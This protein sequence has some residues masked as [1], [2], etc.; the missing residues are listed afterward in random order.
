MLGATAGGVWLIWL[1]SQKSEEERYET[2]KEEFANAQYQNAARSFQTLGDDFT[3]SPR[4]KEY[5][6]MAGLSRALQPAYELGDPKEALETLLHFVGEYEENPLLQQQKQAVHEG[7]AKVTADLAEAA[8][9]FLG[10]KLDLKQARQVLDDAKRAQGQIRLWGADDPT[11]EKVAAVEAA[12]G[13]AERRQTTLQELAAVPATAAGIRQAEQLLARNDLQTDTEAR[14]V[15]DQLKEKFLGTIHY[16]ESTENVL[17]ARAEGRDSHLILVAPV[18]EASIDADGVL[19]AM[20]RGILYALTEKTGKFLWATRVGPDISHL[21]I[22]LVDREEGMEIALVVTSEPTPALVARDVRSGQERWHYSL[23]APCLGRP[24][25]VGSHVFI[26]TLDGRIHEIEAL[27]GK[28]LGWYEVG[29]PFTVG[30]TREDGSDRVYFP[31]DSQYVYVFN[32]AARKCVGILETGHPSGSVRNEPIVVRSDR[33][34]PSAAGTAAANYLIL[35]QTEGLGSTRLRAFPLEVEKLVQGT[36]LEPEP[37]L[38]GWS[39]FAPACDGEKIALTTDAGIFALFG[40]NQARNQDTPLFRLWPEEATAP[41]RQEASPPQRAQVVHA[42]ENDFWVLLGGKL[43]QWRLGIDREKG[44]Q[45]TKQWELAQPLGSPV[46][47]SQVDQRRATLFVVSQPPSEPDYLVTAVATASGRVQWQQRL[48]IVLRGDAV[49]VDGKLLAMNQTSSLMR[50]DP[51]RDGTARREWQLGGQR[52]SSPLG[53][54]VQRAPAFLL[55]APDGRTVYSLNVPTKGTAV[56][57]RRVA[58]GRE[59]ERKT[60]PLSAP[61]AGTPA[62]GEDY[63]LLPL[64]DGTLVWQPWEGRVRY[65]TWRTLQ[66]DRNARGHVVHLGPGEFMTTDGFRGLSHWRWQE[67]DAPKE[68]K[69]EVPDAIVAAPVLGPG[70]G[71]LCVADGS[72]TIRVLQTENLQTV[73]QWPVNGKITAG[74]FVRG[75]AIGCVVNHNRLVWINTGVDSPWEFQAAGEIVG[76]PQVVK[77][78]VV[79]VDQSGQLVALDPAN[80][81]PRGAPFILKG[82]VAPAAAAIPFGPDR[83]FVPLTDGSILLL[84]IEHLLQK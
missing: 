2:A 27:K 75:S 13:K 47:A 39:S 43:Q 58:E 15:I 36:P 11:Q 61:L 8:R 71:E 30:G 74:P 4:R 6:F 14:S 42:E 69:I 35:N 70:T 31:A 64:A 41:A 33:L 63:L 7:F 62:V 38:A 10:P 32:V 17:P 28:L 23:A 18:V 1:S 37:R 49:P 67:G 5:Q 3:E 24:V 51:T 57:V 34:Y 72:G 9:Q 45:L 84:A 65:G 79:V 55:T 46:Q 20:A 76:Q 59:R 80:G 78:S 12:I 77:D 54:S 48:G 21:P 68:K 53:E 22:R 52:L 19:F 40:I 73:R 82:S 56:I 29:L 25:L 81:T 44:F 16:V 66:A 26:G 60:F 83:L 50:F